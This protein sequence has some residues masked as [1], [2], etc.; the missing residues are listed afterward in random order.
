MKL[1]LFAFALQAQ[2]H[3]AIDRI[4]QSHNVPAVSVAVIEAGRIGWARTYGGGDTDT[5]FQAASISKPVSAM[6]ALHMM[7][8]GNF[9][10]DE[11]VNGKL[12][13]WKVPENEFTASEKVTLRRLLSHTAGLTVHGFPG[14]QTGAPMPTLMQILNGEPPA[15]TAAIRVDT[16]PGGKWRYS[17]GGYTVM[18]Q[19]LIDRTGM[20]FPQLM[21]RMVLG[22][23]G[24][25][26][27]SFEQPLPEP[28]A[29]N[30][31]TAH[32]RQG[33]P[34]KGRWHVYPEMAAA[35]LWTTPS[36]LALWAIELRAAYLGKANRIIERTTAAEML[37]PQSG[38]YGLGVGLNRKGPLQFR[39]GGSNAGFRCLMVMYVDSGN[40][41]VIMT[42]SDNGDRAIEQILPL[43]LKTE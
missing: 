8:Y 16:A 1:L 10:L 6:A 15:N 30:A 34:L 28:L 31:A 43:V 27:S 36:D 23:I 9:T 7:Q 11:D 37:K 18:Q 20:P 38:D 22:R 21:Q 33:R 5:L 32:D 14:Y 13:S 17:G 12:K 40:G 26:R 42:N 4:R 39:H 19:L 2:D 29:G 3:A 35:G 25:K 41:A 24:M